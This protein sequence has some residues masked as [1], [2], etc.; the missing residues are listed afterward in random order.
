MMQNGDDGDAIASFKTWDDGDGE[1]ND[2]NGNCNGDGNMQSTTTSINDGYH[3]NDDD[4]EAEE[5]HSSR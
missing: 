5:L 2:G 1:T 3:S 4:I